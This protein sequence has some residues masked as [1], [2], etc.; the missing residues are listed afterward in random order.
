MSTLA[1]LMPTLKSQEHGIIAT[2]K[3]RDF[4]LESDTSVGQNQRAASETGYL[5]A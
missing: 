4:R 5:S 2:G 3:L 1:Q